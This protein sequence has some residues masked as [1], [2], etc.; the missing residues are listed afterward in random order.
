MWVMETQLIHEID[1]RMPA[2]PEGMFP[3]DPFKGYQFEQMA[4]LAFIGPYGTA[5]GESTQLQVEQIAAFRTDAAPTRMMC[6]T[7]WYNTMPRSR[8][9]SWSDAW[10]TMFY[11]YNGLMYFTTDPGSTMSGV[12]T[13]GRP[14]K[15]LRDTADAAREIRDGVFQVVRGAQRQDRDIAI[16]YSESSYLASSLLLEPLHESLSVEQATVWSRILK[17]LGL[18]HTHISSAQI[19]AGG[20]REGQVKTLILPAAIALSERETS[21][22]EQFVRNGGVI[23]ADVLPGV[24]DGNGS[25]R[26]GGALDEMLGVKHD[27]ATL[28]EYPHPQIVGSTQR[29]GEW[30]GNVTLE[31]ANPLEAGDLPLFLSHRVGEGW[32][33]LANTTLRSYLPQRAEGKNRP[34][35]ELIRKW[36][37][38]ADIDARFEFTSTGP[39]SSPDLELLPYRDDAIEYLA[40]IKQSKYSTPGTSS[41][42]IRLPETYNVYDIRE[43]KSL[44]RV[45]ELRG[46]CWG[47]NPRFFALLPYEVSEV[48][49]AEL[50][51]GFS[52]G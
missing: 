3:W 36:F 33:L 23:V 4:S 13:D 31:S 26:A 8:E 49:I 22:I 41:F 45:N 18:P 12:T 37:D 2:G 34:I 7:G 42:A 24:L 28:M 5:H 46:E 6:F 44:G 10:S 1:D 43:Q 11:G 9:Y 16:L 51:A 47:D 17:D 52:A 19:E 29:A 30:T 15:Y 21:E 20:L 27:G 39:H 38:R 32:A 50:P 40:V 48:K 35:S 14:T 25:P